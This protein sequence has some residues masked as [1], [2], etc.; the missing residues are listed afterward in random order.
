MNIFADASAFISFYDPRDSNHL[1]A[2]KL[3]AKFFR[4]PILVSNFVFAETVTIISQRVDKENSI[5][6]GEYIKKKF[7]VVKL[8]EEVEDLAWE[9][10]K[11]QTSKNISFVDCTTFALYEKGLFDKAFTFDR[12]FKKNRVPILE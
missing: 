10:F 3:A 8:T 6:A 12:D 2:K 5:L 11:K 9:I 4:N 1:R 7:S